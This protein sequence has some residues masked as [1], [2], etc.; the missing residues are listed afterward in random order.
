MTREEIEAALG[1]YKTAEED[2]D[3]WCW[4]AARE[5]GKRA[6]RALLRALPVLE[7]AR[8]QVNAG[9]GEAY[10]LP[11]IEATEQVEAA[12][13]AHDAEEAP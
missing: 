13:R 6:L 10:G 2:G 3:T 12:I 5:N 7:A 1:Y 8:E 4:E 11:W 9:A